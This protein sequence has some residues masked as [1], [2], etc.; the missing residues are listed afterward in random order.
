MWFE[1]LLGLK[2]NLGKS[3]IFPTGMVDRMEDLVA[4]L[5]YKIGS[6]PSTYL[7]LPLGASHK[8]IGVWDPFE[9][10][11][12][13]RFA[14]WK[15]QYI[16]KGGRL[17]L[18]RSTLSS[19]PIS[20]MSLFRIPIRVCRRLEKIQRD[21]LWGG[22]NHKPHM[23]N[24]ATVCLDKKN[25]GLGVRGLFNLNKALLGK[26]NWHFANERNLLWRKAGNSKYG[27]MQGGWCSGENRGN[28]GIGVWKEIRKD[29]VTLFDNFKCLI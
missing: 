25:G 9:E 23:V 24:W 3:E 5:G 18:I 27:E 1:A 26:W 6:L 29:W 10:R 16:S 19:L 14:A 28:L 8:S 20:F 22:G 21:F 4:D 15:L 2:I 17:T 13:R 12:R 11:F 7:G